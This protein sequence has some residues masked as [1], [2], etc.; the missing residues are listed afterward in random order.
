MKSVREC[1]TVLIQRESNGQDVRNDGSVRW[2][3]SLCIELQVLCWFLNVCFSLSTIL[4]FNKTLLCFISLQTL[5][6]NQLN[7]HSYIVFPDQLFPC[8][9]FNYK[10]QQILPHI[11]LAGV[12]Y[13][14]IPYA[15]WT[16]LNHHTRT[17]HSRKILDYIPFS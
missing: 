10:N 1:L 17:S 11:Y 13:F 8:F 5:A 3:L 4:V 12:N 15:I 6:F 9:E 7:Y 14:H 2:C 16:P